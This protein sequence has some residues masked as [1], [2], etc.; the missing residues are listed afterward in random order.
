[1]TL[2]KYLVR[3]FMCNH[4]CTCL[5][6]VCPSAGQPSS[7]KVLS[8][9]GSLSPWCQPFKKPTV[10]FVCGHQQRQTAIVRGCNF[11]QT[12]SSG[13]STERA[14]VFCGFTDL[15]S[16]LLS[17]SPFVLCVPAILLFK[18]KLLFW[19][20]LSTSSSPKC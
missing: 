1:M 18:L 7:C 4:V 12:S 13:E 2:Y 5:S 10:A 17:F 15:V 9:S 6:L 8:L 14:L 11:R 20:F 3:N 19:S 16:L